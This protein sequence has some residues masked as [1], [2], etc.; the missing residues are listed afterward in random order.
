MSDADYHEGYF[1]GIR[2]CSWA[3]GNLMIG[4]EQMDMEK[5]QNWLSSEL[6]DAKRIRDEFARDEE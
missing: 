5:F 1:E 2:N 6:A 4:R 3:L